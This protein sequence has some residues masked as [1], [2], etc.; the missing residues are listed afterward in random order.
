VQVRVANKAA[1]PAKIV[2]DSLV[3]GQTVSGTQHW[4]VATSGSVAHVEF[5]VDGLPQATVDAAPYA[6]DWNTSDTT[7]GAHQLTVRAVGIE[8]DVATQTFTV[9]VAAPS[10][11]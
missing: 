7:P 2:S 4:L 5:D 8:G 10:A 9:T 6:Y 11:R 1:L 3:D